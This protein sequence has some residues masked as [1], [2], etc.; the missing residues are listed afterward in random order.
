[1]P[2]YQAKVCIYV[3]KYIGLSTGKIPYAKR[4]MNVV[5]DLKCIR[6]TYIRPCVFI[7]LKTVTCI[8]VSEPQFQNNWFYTE[9]KSI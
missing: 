5:K 6:Y 8:I 3:V 1:M 4:S 7:F 2:E 9:C